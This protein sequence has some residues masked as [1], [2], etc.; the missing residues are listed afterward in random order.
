MANALRPK[1]KGLWGKEIWKDPNIVLLRL[2]KH[3]R[4]IATAWPHCCGGHVAAMSGAHTAK[5]PERERTERD[6]MEKRGIRATTTLVRIRTRNNPRSTVAST[7]RCL[8][9]PR[10]R[11]LLRSLRGKG[12]AAHGLSCATQEPAAPE[13]HL[14]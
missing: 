11:M 2:R 3:R 14:T 10:V 8:P 12:S 1:F 13:Y 9:A 5:T 6:K 4:N 7:F